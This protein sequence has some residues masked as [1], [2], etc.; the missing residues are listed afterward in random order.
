MP[1]ATYRHEGRKVDHTPGSAVTAGDVIDLGSGLVG[2]ADR[3]IAASDLGAVAIEG[4]FDLTKEAGGGVTFAVG[5]VVDWDDTNNTSVAATT[6]DFAAGKA[7]AAAAD[8]DSTV[9]VK[10]N[11]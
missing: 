4:V 8:G 11:I 9:R 6:G 7:V 5:A 2:I 3:D 10:I 1:Q